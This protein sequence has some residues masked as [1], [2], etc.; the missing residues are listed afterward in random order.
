MSFFGTSSR[1]APAAPAPYAGPLISLRNVEKSFDTAAGRS[2][3]L[4]RI[5][6]DIAPGEFISIMGP[7]GA[8]KSTLLSIIGMLDS[9]WSG[10][11]YLLGQ[12]VHAL[13]QKQRVALN[14]QHIG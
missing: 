10:E 8:G 14:K 2:F 11:Y 1:P 3:V 7:S 13:P 5:S 12:A 4:R 9:A 6:A